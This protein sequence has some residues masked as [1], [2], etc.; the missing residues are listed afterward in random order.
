[1]H[2]IRTALLKLAAEE[3]TV[4]PVIVPMAR[5]ADKWE[6]MPKG[7]DASSRKKFWDTLT[8]DNKHKVTKCIKEMSK[9]G[10]DIDD[11]GAF[12]AALADRVLGKD[13]RKKK[14]KT[15][16]LDEGMEMFNQWY[17]STGH[18]VYPTR[19]KALKTWQTR[20]IEN[21]PDYKRLKKATGKQAR[22]PSELSL[23]EDR[24][25]KM[26]RFYPNWVLDT[27]AAFAKNPDAPGR[28]RDLA[29]AAQG[30]VMSV[31]NVQSLR[32]R[33]PALDTLMPRTE[34]VMKAAKAR[35]YQVDEA[36]QA[37]VDSG[38]GA[39]RQVQRAVQNYL[40]AVEPIYKVTGLSKRAAQEKQA[41]PALRQMQ[42]QQMRQMRD[43]P[44]EKKRREDEA[45]ARREREKAEK[46]KREKAD[47]EKQE[48]A[49]AKAEEK[50]KAYKEKHPNTKKTPADFMGWKGWFRGAEQVAFANCVE[51]VA[52]RVAAHEQ[53]PNAVDGA[54]ARFKDHLDL[55]INEHF[56]MAHPEQV[57]PTLTLLHGN[58][59]IR[60]IKA[61]GGLKREAVAF[62]ARA[63]GNVYLAATW[64]RPLPHVI[65][66]VLQSDTWRS[67][68]MAFD[69]YNV[70]ELLG[71]LKKLL[72]EKGLD[73]TWDEIQKC[74]VPRKVND[75][76]MSLSPKERRKRASRLAELRS[77][78]QAA[79]NAWTRAYV[80]SK[81]FGKPVWGLRFESHYR[82][83]PV[84]D[85][86]QGKREAARMEREESRLHKQVL[87][88]FARILPKGF[89]AK[90]TANT[91]HHKASGRYPA[92]AH[93]SVH[94][95][96]T[97]PDNP[98]PKDPY[99]RVQVNAAVK[100]LEQAGFKDNSRAYD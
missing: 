10:K 57:P 14:A 11:P 85:D 41:N 60:V 80:F 61:D 56:R 7:W 84:E 76:W 37:L 79:D 89:T 16:T 94:T 6:D 33:N 86:A 8:G 44:R 38:P 100:A 52:T 90:T 26:I 32:S 40:K 9:P 2:N 39:L 3:P 12:C 20:G 54:A 36:V 15:W 58:D 47:K 46:E 48:K 78:R 82:Q 70:P 53:M 67:M 13:W 49:K 1:M 68:R 65:A 23:F 63:T 98:D 22:F 25:E 4:R 31:Q 62:I 55:K 19:E 88:K 30:L 97:V 73:D 34:Q 18:W 93:T 35:S 99:S 71:Q 29:A 50:F 75:A 24:I 42:M 95:V 72:L 51:R 81:D 83:T 64:D 87:A 66:N 74:Q 69:Q 96:L 21:L 92:Q 28:R 27:A 91:S 45:K 43:D 77:Q 59:L 17:K 5:Q